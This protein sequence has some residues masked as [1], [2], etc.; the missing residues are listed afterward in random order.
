MTRP[1]D[2]RPP[3]RAGWFTGQLACLAHN[4][5]GQMLVDPLYSLNEVGVRVSFGDSTVWLEELVVC[6]S[7]RPPAP[8][9]LTG[10]T[11]VIGTMPAQE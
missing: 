11:E 4:R 10:E 5:L 7:Y 2:H 3:G 9:E 8:N 6:A 1:G